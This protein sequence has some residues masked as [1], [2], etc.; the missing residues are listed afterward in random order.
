MILQLA[1]SLKIRIKQYRAVAS[2]DIKQ[3]HIAASNNIGQCC[4]AAS[5]DI[6]GDTAELRVMTHRKFHSA[7]SN[8]IKLYRS[9]ASINIR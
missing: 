8:D 5:N 4:S 6:S 7:A 9:V 2:K 3:H 1:V